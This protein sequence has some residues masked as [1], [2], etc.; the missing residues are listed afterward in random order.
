MSKEYPTRAAG[1]PSRPVLPP[2]AEDE[3]LT[4]LFTNMKISSGEIAAILK[5][6]DVSCDT[7]VL[8]DRYRKRLGQR[9]MASIRD[10]CG[11]REVLAR[12]SEYIVLEC[13]N[14][15]QVL[16][17]IRRRIQSQVNGLDVSAAKV[18]GRIHV[19]D[20]FLARFRKAG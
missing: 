15:Q 12:G 5:K 11:Q 1:P 13:C 16:K 10:E 7:E 4:A 17:A 9:L 14:D 8:Q 18:G 6:H 20:R 3:I 19:L 2:E